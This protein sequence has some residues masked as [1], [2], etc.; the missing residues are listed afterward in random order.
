MTDM[1]SKVMNATNKLSSF[2]LLFGMFV[3]IVLNPAT[4]STRLCESRCEEA[5]SDLRRLRL[6]W[7]HLSKREGNEEISFTEFVKKLVY[8][9]GK[10]KHLKS[11]MHEVVGAVLQ[12]QDC[13][14][15]CEHQH[16]KRSGRNTLTNRQN[17]F[18]YTPTFCVVRI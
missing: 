18:C 3:L 9:T 5:V 11:L 15:A 8:A 12:Y 1:L 4:V 7:H 17:I 16:S 10:R 13:M 2:T 14:K 6:I